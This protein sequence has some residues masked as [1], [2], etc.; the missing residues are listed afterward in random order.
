MSLTA[1]LL[2]WLALGALAA[3]VGIGYDVRKKKFTWTPE[4][5]KATAILFTGGAVSLVIVLWELNKELT[6]ERKNKRR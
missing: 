4:A 5:R 6:W 2:L 3:L 1:V